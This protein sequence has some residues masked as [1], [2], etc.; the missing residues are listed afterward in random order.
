MSRGAPGSGFTPGD[1]PLNAGDQ[2]QVERD[3]RVVQA[4]RDQPAAP[5]ECN[6]LRV[7]DVVLFAISNVDAER[8]ERP[9]GEQ[10][11]D[12]LGGH[13]GRLYQTRGLRVRQRA[14]TSQSSCERRDRRLGGAGRR[15]WYS[16]C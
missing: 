12:L 6:V 14:A 4:D 15:A 5:A 1:W 3:E 16:L 7:T 8:L 2:Q 11:L 13:G 10:S 9:G